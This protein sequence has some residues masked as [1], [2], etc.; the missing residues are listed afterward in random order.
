MHKLLAGALA[1][2]F[3][4]SLASCITTTIKAVK[5]GDALTSDVGYIAVVFTNKMETISMASRKVYVEL[6]HVDSGRRFYI[7]FGYNGELR[8]IAVTPGNY[9][10]KDFIYQGGIESV[11]GDDIQNPGVIDGKP[12]RTGT[13]LESAK[14]PDTY[15]KDF[16]VNAGEIVYLGDY[17]WEGALAIF[18]SALKISKSAES[19][20][21]VQAAI[22]KA[23]PTI[24]ASMK[25]VPLAE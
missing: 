17:S 22:L 16:T 21:A 3:L 1:A 15:C 24:D 6:R 8:L 25:Y 10:I 11:T 20:D 14:Y 23:H 13:I 7:P 4:V 5:P 12:G 2:L 19:D 18:E 9:R